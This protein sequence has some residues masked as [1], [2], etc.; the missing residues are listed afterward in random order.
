MAEVVAVF[1]EEEKAMIRHHLGY[2]NVSAVSTFALGVAAG[3]ETNFIIERAMELVKPSAAPIVRRLIATLDQ[4]ETQMVDDIE[5]L[6]ITSLGEIDI[7]V[8]EQRDL[9]DQYLYWGGALANCI[10]AIRNPFDMR[11]S[12][13]GAAGINVSVNNG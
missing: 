2:Q 1:N 11:F 4:I 5:L 9:R 13:S 6:A 12:T 10:G 3:V 8:T 7:R